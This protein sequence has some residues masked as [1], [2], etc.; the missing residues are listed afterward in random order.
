MDLALRMWEGARKREKNKCNENLKT[1][2]NHSFQLPLQSILSDREESQLKSHR[3]IDDVG[4]K[5]E[6]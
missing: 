1:C 6:L 4:L 3:L 5:G 2:A